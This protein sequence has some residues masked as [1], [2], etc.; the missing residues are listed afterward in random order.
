MIP[1]L[2]SLRKLCFVRLDIT[3]GWGRS[4]RTCE[5]TK[6]LLIHHSKYYSDSVTYNQFEDSEIGR[7]QYYSKLLD[8]IKKEYGNLVIL[9]FSCHEELHRLA[10]LEYHVWTCITHKS[11][12]DQWY[13]KS[14]MEDLVRTY[15]ENYSLEIKN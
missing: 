8:E 6:G 1:A 12:A 3:T 5:T 7:L 4:C 13:D 2:K 10:K 9:C 15:Y 14:M 11:T